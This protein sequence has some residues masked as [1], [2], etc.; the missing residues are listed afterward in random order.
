MRRIA[1]L[2]AELSGLR[3]RQ[4]RILVVG[5][6]G[7]GK[8]STINSIV[9]AQVADVGDFEPTTPE[10]RFYN[11]QINESPILLID[12]PGFCDARPDRSNDRAYVDLIKQLVGEI[13]L[14]LFVTRLDDA[15]VEASEWATLKVLSKSLSRSI[16]QH[17]VVVLT[18]ADMV[19]RANF[20]YHLDGRSAALRKA[21]S[22]IVGDHAEIPFIPVSNMRQR[23]PDRRIWMSRLWLEMLERMSD[24]GFEPFVL[25]TINRVDI[26]TE[27]KTSRRSRS[28]SGPP[29]GARKPQTAGASPVIT[30]ARRDSSP[31]P[32]QKTQR[33]NPSALVPPTT[34]QLVVPVPMSN[35]AST[36]AVEYQ[37]YAHPA[38]RI[39]ETRFEVDQGIGPIIVNGG[40]VHIA[41]QVIERR[42]PRLVTAI[43]AAAV[44]V[45]NRVKSVFGW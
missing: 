38:A 23:T 43:Q 28:G 34:S 35:A 32:A 22:D 10:I 18:R 12:T 40:E 20:G 30:S 6:T 25:A 31:P 45:A 26:A 3:G 4:T 27:N 39:V 16:W 7:V 8:S 9:G 42:A 15:R 11:G 44:W 2:Q 13:D 29:S 17:S 14:L 21:F 1:E 5:R 24:R 36:T 33:T 41:Q 37:E 19:T